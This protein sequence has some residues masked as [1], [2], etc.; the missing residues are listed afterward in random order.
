MTLWK[1]RLE[2]GSRAVYLAIADAIERDIEQ[3]VLGAGGRLPTHRALAEQLGITAVTVTRAYGEAARR[4]LLDA[5]VG[6]GT[7][8]RTRGRAAA[9]E[10][11]PLDFARNII[12]GNED[13]QVPRDFAGALRD[14]LRNPDYQFPRSGSARHRAAGAEWISRS[15]PRPDP[16][17]VIVAPG[18]QPALLAIVA[19][20]LRPGDRILCE[21]LMYPG[22]RSVLALLGIDAEPLTVDANGLQPRAFDA[23]CRAT[24]SK[25][26]Y[27]VPNFQNPTGSLMS[28]ERR[29]EIAAIARRRDVTILEDDVYGFMTPRNFPTL[30][31]L[32][33]EQTC[34]VVS[35]AKSLSP[36]LRLGFIAA[37][38][39]LAARIESSLAAAVTFSST[40]AAEIFTLLLESGEVERIERRKERVVVANQQ[41]ARRIFGDALGATHERSPHAWLTL[42]RDR[43]ANAVVN[44][45][46][47]RGYALA[48]ASVFAVDRRNV[49]NAIR[50]SIG[51][52]SDT[53]ELEYALTA[54]AGIAEGSHLCD[55]AVL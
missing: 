35:A 55:A 28:A 52:T 50:L 26:L 3:G 44:E 49:P 41:I 13:L 10:G 39:A 54:I 24:G 16:E 27:C 7:F 30:A 5:T 53:R 14:V 32:L 19:A 42:P 37:P 1:P 2:K 6:R 15:G 40:A 21:E 31:S 25:V 46:G 4:G 51:T 11:R 9:D 48:P 36:A 17:H 22:F 47:C 23:A 18:A 20:L 8:V 38:R 33:P 29:Q 34:Y 43:D 45:A 12:C